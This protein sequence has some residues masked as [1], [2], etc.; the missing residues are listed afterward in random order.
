MSKWNIAK[1]KSILIVYSLLC[2]CAT[3]WSQAAQISNL[4]DVPQLD[5][6]VEDEFENEHDIG[7]LD[8]ED[9]E[10]VDQEFS[11]SSGFQ[12][13]QDFLA[14][15]LQSIVGDNT[16][17]HDPFSGKLIS[18]N[19]YK[20]YVD[21]QV[22][23]DSS[24]R[25]QDKDKIDVDNVFFKG[26]GFSLINWEDTNPINWLDFDT[27]RANRNFRDTH[28]N[29]KLKRRERDKKE[30]LGK[31][32]S[33]V[34]TCGIY[35]GKIAA[36]AS[37]LSRVL[38]GD[39]IT[40]AKDS[41]MWLFLMDGTLVRI[42]PETSISFNEF[43]ISNKKFFHFARLN[44]GHILWYSRI[45]GEYKSSLL[46]ETDTLFL[47]LKLKEANIEQFLRKKYQKL[48]QSQ[49]NKDIYDPINATKDQVKFLNNKISSNFK[50]SNKTSEVLLVLPNCTIN[51][52]NAVLDVFSESG[53]VTYIRSR[54]IRSQFKGDVNFD[55]KTFLF[56]RGYNNKKSRSLDL[57]QWY[58]VSIEGRDY[59]EVEKIP[60]SFY[61]ME[62]LTKRIPTILTA[63]ELMLE[64]FSKQIFNNKLIYEDFAFM[65]GYRLW[66]AKRESDTNDRTYELNKRKGFLINY[67]RRV[68]TTNLRSLFKLLDKLENEGKLNLT[69]FDEQY[70]GK[71]YKDYLMT[72]SNIFSQDHDLVKEYKD[73]QYYI[74][75]LSHSKGN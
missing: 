19:K 50:S 48:S 65:T 32:I 37:Y 43:N 20:K 36:N 21:T 64:K 49:K 45:L 40:T 11:G 26:Q 67:T 34:G 63:R 17:Y 8:E 72:I 28:K 18:A 51:A 16:F 56:F 14:P 60:Q 23:A 59:S 42:S 39:E 12:N 24:W 62:F 38:E 2:F 9:G 31:V 66:G 53:N 22:E 6:S 7:S 73:M 68:E 52:E 71:A 35:R 54:D 13:P 46:H 33:C 3:N 55:P 25:L 44:Q 30:L 58:S 5:S 74:W 61:W 57:G 29:W 27:W 4:N 10:F 41:Y 75:N 69:G 47:P 15:K 70:F 1:F